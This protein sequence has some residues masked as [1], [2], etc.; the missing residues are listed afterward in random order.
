[1]EHI[2]ISNSS[3]ATLVAEIFRFIIRTTDLKDP[4]SNLNCLLSRRDYQAS[5]LDFLATLFPKN[6]IDSRER[7][8]ELKTSTDCSA[9]GGH[10]FKTYF[11]GRQKHITLLESESQIDEDHDGT[12]GNII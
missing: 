3:L 6:D 4:V 10:S 9:A 1:M 7:V 11:L 8:R 5:F 2:D 12:T